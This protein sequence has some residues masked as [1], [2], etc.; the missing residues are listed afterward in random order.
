[1][2][3][4]FVQMEIVMEN[5]LPSQLLILSVLWSAS[6]SLGIIE[7]NI[8]VFINFQ[9]E[10]LKFGW[11]IS[12][13]RDGTARIWRFE[14]A[15]WRSILLDMSDRLL[16][17]TCA[18]EDKFMKPKVTMIAWNQNDNYVVTAV[19]NHLLIWNSST[20]QLLH[21]LVGHADEVFV[22]ET[23]PFDCRIMLSA[24]HDG[25]IFI[26]DITKGTKT[27]HY[28]NMIEGQGH[29]AVFDCKFSPD[30]QHFACTDSHGHL[31]IFGLA[32]AGLMKRRPSLDIQS[33]PNI[34]L[35]RSGQ[36][37][38]VRQ[39]HQNAPRSQMATERGPAGLEAQ[40]GGARDPPQLAQ[41]KSLAEAVSTIQTMVT[42]FLGR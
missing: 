24:G 7:V 5:E 10:Q 33:P 13:S 27:K 18:E 4:L 3:E 9:F 39:M 25:N 41:C 17:D 38:G 30:G 20:G 6:S 8:R 31:L 23:H 28:F 12:G 19:N 34:G 15:E 29:G 14:Q 42:S 37:E 32:V 36:V 40:G 1:M 35:R 26:W 2:T 21:D 16:G 11:F 22:L